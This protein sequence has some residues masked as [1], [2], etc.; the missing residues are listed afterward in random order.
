MSMLPAGRSLSGFLSDLEDLLEQ[1]ALYLAERPVTVG[2]RRMYGLAALF[3]VAGA[4]FVL[5]CVFFPV[6]GERLAMG[7][8][9]LVGASV[10]LGWSLLMRGHELI[11][12][13]DGVEVKY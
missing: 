9:L 8:G 11:L 2:P 12:R 13:H 7:I 3:G 6:S 10:W 5:S 1:P 4:A